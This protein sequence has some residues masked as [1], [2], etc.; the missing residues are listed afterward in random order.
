MPNA[1]KLP[2]WV[3][4][5]I[6]A[7]TPEPVVKLVDTRVS[8]LIKSVGD[9]SELAVLGDYVLVVTYVRPEKTKGGIIRVDST[10]KEDEHQGKVGLV[11]AL[12]ATAFQYRGA[13]K[14]EGRAARVGE[15]ISYRVSDGWSL[16]VN[17]VHC[18]MIDCNDVRMILPSPETIY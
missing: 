14:Y 1:S 5:A 7:E 15:W 4:D 3:N 11:V 8:D 2:E 13:F 9:L 18:R 10:L 17:G 16:L 12:G 6:V